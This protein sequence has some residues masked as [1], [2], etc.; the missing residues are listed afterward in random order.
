MTDSSARSGAAESEPVQGVRPESQPALDGTAD[1]PEGP[2]PE[3]PGA[4]VT[5]AV[6]FSH[7]PAPAARPVYVPAA[8]RYAGEWS[9]RLIVIAVALAG[10]GYVISPLSTILIAVLVAL[11][12]AVL[13]APLATL[14]IRRAKFPPILASF[15]TVILALGVI[16]GLLGFAGQQIFSQFSLLRD[17]AIEG[18]NQLTEMLANGPLAVTGETLQQ[19]GDQAVAWVEENS[20]NLASGVLSVGSTIADIAVGIVIVI[21]ALIFFLKDGRRIWQWFVRLAPA[22]AREATNEAGIRA[23]VTLGDYA[24]TQILVAFIDAVGIS[25]GAAI[26]GVPFVIPIGVLVFLFSFI[27]IVGAFISGAIAVLVALV[28][29]GWV[30]AL[31]MLG[32]VVLVQQLEGNVFQPLLMSG[33]VSLH[34][35]V[36]F[37]AV[38]AGS[39]LFGLAGA[40]F[41]V[42]FCAMVNTIVLYLSG[43]DSMPELN[44]QWKRP[45]GPPGVLLPSIIESYRKPTKE[46]PRLSDIE[47]DRIVLENAGG[48]EQPPVP[49]PADAHIALNREAARWRD[50]H[51]GPQV[52]APFQVEGEGPEEGNVPDRVTHGSHEAR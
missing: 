45:G 20:Q 31:I 40:L 51:E 14:L 30:V 29:Q 4:N 46:R 3:D 50:P 47:L 41:S 48:P 32:V 42:P 22:Q 19:W 2:T 44:A 21:F 38:M 6:T 35:L 37:L 17:S 8:L 1:L 9:W 52:P 18:W 13:L 27:P 25:I 11:I 43:H 28:T 5:D 24:R 49:T 36:T 15:I 39:T 7:E 33:A 10:L 12:L 23:W 34:P 26:L 16:A